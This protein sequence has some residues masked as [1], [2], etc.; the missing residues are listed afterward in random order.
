MV[1]WVTASAGEDQEELRGQ[2][3]PCYSVFSGSYF[4]CIKIYGYYF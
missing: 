2:A 1:E 4:R 3:L